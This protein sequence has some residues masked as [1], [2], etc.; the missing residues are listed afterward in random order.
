MA[1]KVLFTLVG[2]MVVVLFLAF[3]WWTHPFSH[4]D[5][6]WSGFMYKVF[7]FLFFASGLNFA[8]SVMMLIY[9]IRKGMRYN[10]QDNITTGVQ[11]IYVLIIAMAVVF[12]LMSLWGIDFGTLFTS[13]SIVA[14]AIAIVSKEFISSIIAGFVIVFSKQISIGDYVK[15]GDQKG[16]VV[17]LTLTKLALVN[18]DEDVIYISN[19]KAYHS[20]IINYTK[21]EIKRVSIPFELNASFKGTVEELEENLIRELEIYKKE[22]DPKSFYLRI[23]E[24]KKDAITFKFQYS[25]DKINRTLEKEIKR[26]TARRVLNYIKSKAT[27]KSNGN[28]D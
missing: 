8:L 10:S 24:I 7:G 23:V 17:D 1:R 19:D 13:L 18:E 28:S 27:A 2:K 6:P 5:Q 12:F 15:I 3:L 25:L 22:I 9:R 11:N 4:L 21:G 16:K 14:A 26:K 20:E